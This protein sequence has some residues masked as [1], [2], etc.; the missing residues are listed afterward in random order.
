[1]RSLHE[2]QVQF[3]RHLFDPSDESVITQVCANRLNPKR[4]LGIYRNN[5]V[6]SLSEALRACYPVVERLIGAGCFHFAARS[7]LA[8]HPSTCAN[9]HEFGASFARFLGNF[10]TLSALVYLEDVA[11]LEWVQQ[12]V[13][14]AADT[15]PLD[16][17]SLRAVPVQHHGD[18]RF[19]VN[20]ALQLFESRYPAVR[21]WQVNQPRY[22]GDQTVDLGCGGDRL[23][24][25]RRG[26]AIQLSAVSAAVFALVAGFVAGDTLS[27]AFERALRLEPA[28]DLPSVL[29]T[30]VLNQTITSY[31][32]DSTR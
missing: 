14:H 2:L 5:M 1:M 27:Q 20:P 17:N 6:A 19:A 22:Q 24:V 32:L 26:L 23:F 31:R 15:A 30:L 21:I 3:A 11:R 12:L 8:D 4:R 7:Y 25:S 13:Y 18:L 29:K 28:F 9:L 10:P 16:W